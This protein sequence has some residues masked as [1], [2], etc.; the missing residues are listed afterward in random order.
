MDNLPD[1]N[2]ANKHLD[3][4][5]SKKAGKQQ[6]SLLKRVSDETWRSKTII[7]HK[8]YF[9]TLH[10]SRKWVKPGKTDWSKYRTDVRVLNR[11]QHSYEE[12]KERNREQWPFQ[13]LTPVHGYSPLKIVRLVMMGCFTFTEAVPGT[14]LSPTPVKCVW[15]RKGSSSTDTWQCPITV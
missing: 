11:M 3:C 10:S 15:G 9:P 2:V 1:N 5:L 6:P 12:S 8:A 13:K 14:K 4:V 7:V